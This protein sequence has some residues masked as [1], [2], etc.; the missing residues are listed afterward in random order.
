MQLKIHM[1]EQSFYPKMD[2]N[3]LPVAANSTTIVDIL[4]NSPYARVSLSS[5]YILFL[6]PLFVTIV[7]L[8]LMVLVVMLYA[9][10][11]IC[12]F[13]NS[14]KGDLKTQIKATILGF[15]VASFNRILIFV[16]LD[17]AAL[18]F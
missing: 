5:E 6:C 17:V 9:C 10:G 15:T 16:V 7:I 2:D 14:M 4:S 12:K 11:G 18:V 8:A 13:K 1:Q 3:Y